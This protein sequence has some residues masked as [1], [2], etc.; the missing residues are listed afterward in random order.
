MGKKCMICNEEAK[1]AIKG[2]SDFYCEHCAEE[3]FD[4]V[5]SL[6]KL[7]EQ[8]KKEKAKMDDDDEFDDED[9]FE[10]DAGSEEE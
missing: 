2:T 8:E 6:V 1:Y 4:D 10:D 7:D 5:T 9:D 3:N